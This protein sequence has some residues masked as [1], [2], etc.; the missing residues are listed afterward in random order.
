P[1]RG[2]SRAAA[3]RVRAMRPTTM[4]RDPWRNTPV[5]RTALRRRDASRGDRAR[6]ALWDRGLEE[7][8]KLAWEVHRN[9]GVHGPLLVEEALGAAQ[10]E[11]AFV[12]DIRVDVEAVLAAEAKTHEPL[13]CDVI[14]REG[15]GHIERPAFERKKHLSAVRVVVRMPEHHSSRPVA[16]ILACR[17]RRLSVG[18][19]VVTIDGLVSA[20]Q[21]IAA[22][23]AH[24]YAFG[25]AALVAGAGIDRPRAKRWPPAD[26]DTTFLRVVDQP[27]VPLEGRRRCV[28]DGHQ[29]AGQPRRKLRVEIVDGFEGLIGNAHLARLA[30]RARTGSAS[31]PNPATDSTSDSALPSR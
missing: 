13:R 5:R 24:E 18:E 28:H 23:F 17:L 7:T 6:T 2:R 20:V 19:Y 31:F 11:H 12:P 30:L 9:A 1:T 4:A 8:S 26:L 21:D 14:A 29:H 25:G 15:E 10:R 16:V 3:G 27:A 22:P